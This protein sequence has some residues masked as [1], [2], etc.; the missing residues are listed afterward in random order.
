MKPYTLRSRLRGF[1][2]VELMIALLL[3]LLVIGGASSVFLSNKQSYRTNEAIGRLQ[4]NARVAFDLIAR[5]IR[6]AALTGCGNSGRVANVLNNSA[7]A[8]WANWA[9]VVA[10]YGGTSA[11]SNPSL[12]TGTGSA[13]HVTGTDSIILIGASDSGYGIS[14][15]ANGTSTSSPAGFQISEGSSDL[16]V[17][18]VIVVC[19]PDHA[20]IT[21]ITSINGSSF[22]T[23]KTDT[24]T[25][26]T[27]PGNCSH[28]L[29]YPTLCSSTASYTFLRNSLL[30]K[31]KAVSWYMAANPQGTTSLYRMTLQ[32]ATLPGG[33]PT[34]SPTPQEMVRNVTNFQLR[35]HMSGG[36]AF[37]DAA[38]V[39]AAGSA[40]WATVDAVQVTITMQSADTRA[41]ARAQPITRQMITTIALRNRVN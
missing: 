41:G 37:V 21:Q 5:D 4:E 14:N 11:D 26:T 8:W 27:S 33:V 6:N 12:T 34:A 19:D 7:T 20:T 10:G 35:Y 40:N 32:T 38:G 13:Q 39:G 24:T 15:N 3:G 23:E 29:S 30:S 28:D 22:I 36:A 16:Q 17:G 18:D 1:S 9:N 31:L 25:P 2:L